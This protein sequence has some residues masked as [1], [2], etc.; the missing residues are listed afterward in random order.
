MMRLELWCA[1]LCAHRVLA[2]AV[3]EDA[4]VHWELLGESAKGTSLKGTSLML[5]HRGLQRGGTELVGSPG[6]ACP[7]LITEIEELVRATQT[8][9]QLVVSLP[10]VPL[11]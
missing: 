4:G 1:L 8:L 3:V 9:H 2:A 6:T 11:P 10:L 5:P 7:C